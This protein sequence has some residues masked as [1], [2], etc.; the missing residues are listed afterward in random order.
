M[1]N[2]FILIFYLFCCTGVFGQYSFSGNTSDSIGGKTVYLSIIEDYR[3]LSRT[4]L[5]Q[6]LKKT[7][8]DS[9]G[10]F[11]FTGD[12][13]LNDNRIYKIH[14]DDCT[15]ESNGN[16][17]F[18]NCTNTK[19]VL[20]I[21]KAND[22]IYL[23]A[24]FNDELFCDLNST[25]AS[26]IDLLNIDG[27]LDNMAFDYASFNSDANKRL[28][29]Q[30]WFKKLQEYGESLHEPLSELYIYQFLSDRRNETFDF[31]VKDLPDNEYYLE[32]MQ[33]L[34]EKYPS[35]SFSNQY[36]S[37]MKSFLAFY[38]SDKMSNNIW[39]LLLSVLLL[40]SILMNAYLWNSQKRFRVAK[41]NQL[42]NE[43]SQQEKKVVH[44]INKG[45]SNKEIAS[46][47]FISV[48]TVKSHI[49]NIYK[50]LDVKSERST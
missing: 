4:Y 3:K 6:I 49:N 20:F 32:L 25:N 5:E 41:N 48:S 40:L 47:L 38:Q 8:T 43:L 11:E 45:L 35:A 29:S 18:G 28:T 21:A 37:E 46:T 34:N 39:M 2:R 24:T 30:K 12:N 15:E 22:T 33:R 9:T 23:P 42:A 31:F 19:S 14:I 36:Q 7:V 10:Y 17:F 26:S 27:L 50:K 1:V 13:L 16:H 44:H